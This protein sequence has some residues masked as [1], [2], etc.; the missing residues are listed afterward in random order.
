MGILWCRKTT[1][2]AENKWNGLF[3][4]LFQRTVWSC[5]S[6]GSS[7]SFPHSSLHSSVIDTVGN[8]WFFWCDYYNRQFLEEGECRVLIIR[9]NQTIKGF[10][11]SSCFIYI[12]PLCS[13]C[14]KLI[15]RDS[16]EVMTQ[17]G[18]CHWKNLRYSQFPRE[19]DM[20]Y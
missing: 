20:P 18:Q 19:G 11:T 2:M 14:P 5:V 10:I 1:L 3:E 13:L 17:R 15:Y 6:Q 8:S 4:V 16:V 9:I 7:I 12:A